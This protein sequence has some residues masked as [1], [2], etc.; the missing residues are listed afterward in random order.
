VSAPR[1][2]GVPART[3]VGFASYL[4][5]TDWHHDHVI[6]EAWLDGRWRRFDPEIAEPLPA[7]ADPTDIPA[8]AES[9]F[10]TAAHAWIAYR[11]QGLD[12]AHF[13]V[14][15]GVGID[16]D[17]FVYDYVIGQ[18]AHRF[19]DELL[20]W[21]TWGAMH[22]DLADAPAEHLALVDEVTHLLVRADDGDLG[23]EEELLARYQ[24]DDRL[25]PGPTIHSASPYG[26]FSEV[27]LAT[28]TTTPLS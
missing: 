2:H 23:A 12:L 21:D 19:G 27:D 26:G 17:W 22:G 4:R 10:L 25:H 13:G 8:G 28:R 7:L 20:L 16:G 15:E 14:G 5:D 3:R 1:H 6:V 9:P 11:E 24:S 18:V